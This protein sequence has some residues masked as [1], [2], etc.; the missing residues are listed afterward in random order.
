MADMSIMIATKRDY[1]TRPYQIEGKFLWNFLISAPR[2]DTFAEK[3]K[4]KTLIS[5]AMTLV[6]TSIITC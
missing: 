3:R 4:F 5:R 2:D 6:V 1:E